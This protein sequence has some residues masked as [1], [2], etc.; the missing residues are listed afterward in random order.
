MSE[1]LSS[2]SK[3]R[4]MM[5]T[6]VSPAHLNYVLSIHDLDSAYVFVGGLAYDLS[7]GDVVTIMSQYVYIPRTD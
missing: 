1:S 5:S 4:G 2:A 6:R 7:E 3:A